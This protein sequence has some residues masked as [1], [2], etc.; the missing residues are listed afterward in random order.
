ML[1]S[2]PL[3]TVTATLLLIVALPRIARV[4]AAERAQ[5]LGPQSVVR[6]FCQVDGLGQRVSIAGWNDVA[7]LVSWAFEPAWDHALLIAG[8]EVG[9]P[10]AVEGH[11]AAL[12]VEV[13]YQV[14]A[15]VSALGVDNTTTVETSSFRVRTAD[16]V[17]WRIV[18]PPP[19][20]HIFSTRADVDAMRQSFQTG[21]VNF[22]PNSLFIWHMF[23]SAGWAIDFQPAEQLLNGRGFRVVMQPAP[24]DVVLYL[25]D[26]VP[27]HAGL[28]EAENQ[29]VSSTLNAGIVRT[30]ANAFPGEMRYVRLIEPAPA[31]PP[32]P[33]VATPVVVPTAAAKGR[34]APTPKHVAVKT[35]RHRV[36]PGAT[37]DRKAGASRAKLSVPKH[38]KND[39]KHAAKHRKRKP[40]RKVATPASR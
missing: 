30:A 38:V 3:V 33:V 29:I 31:P 15:K 36:H 8:Y 20:P 22:V 13:R 25:R 17:N 11:E 2:K 24:G 4:S 16:Q 28:L 1:G 23:Q 10:H 21:G 18:G 6:R 27:Y 7:P 32:T 19:S 40:E 5:S 14:V 35:P 12:A 9:S 34:G 39:K 37:T 26:G